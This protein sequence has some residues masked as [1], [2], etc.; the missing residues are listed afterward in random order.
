MN[1]KDTEFFSE[2]YSKLLE[3]EDFI[4]REGYTDRVMSSMVIGLIE[5]E[6]GNELEVK[7]VYSYNLVSRQELQV[8]KDIMD[9]TYVDEQDSGLGG[10]LGDLGIELE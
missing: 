4:D 2:L 8:M 5:N 7:S 3:I 9:R 6:K 1:Y 10:F